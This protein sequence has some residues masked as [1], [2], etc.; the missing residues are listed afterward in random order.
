MLDFYIFADLY[1]LML[2]WVYKKF[3]DTQTLTK[4]Q[5]ITLLCWHIC[6][7]GL[8]IKQK[9]KKN[10][11]DFQGMSY[12]FQ[13]K[14]LVITI[15]ILNE[16]KTWMKKLVKVFKNLMSV[17]CYMCTSSVV[18]MQSPTA[19][20]ISSHP[21]VDMLDRADVLDALFVPSWHLWW[22][23]AASFWGEGP[24]QCSSYTAVCKEE[25]SGIASLWAPRGHMTHS[26]AFTSVACRSSA[27]D[28]L[29]F[30]LGFVGI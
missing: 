26:V 16:L 9:K 12:P 19:S 8:L 28:V 23:I 20:L 22:P 30:L 14:K 11:T 5:I 17:I 4:S 10:E 1:L 18:Y 3:H 29:V 6:M 15:N 13:T 25:N 21:Y 2:N 27:L 7:F 24:S